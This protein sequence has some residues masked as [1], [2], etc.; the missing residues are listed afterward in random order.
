MPHI[1]CMH[2]QELASQDAMRSQKL[3]HSKEITKLRQEFEL[4][5]KEL[6]QKY[7]KKMKVGVEAQV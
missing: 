5:A 3:E 4:Q 7:E 6:Q 2:P 1:F